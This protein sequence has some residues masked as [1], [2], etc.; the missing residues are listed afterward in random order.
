MRPLRLNAQVS[1]SKASRADALIQVP[2]ALLGKT[3]SQA[4]KTSR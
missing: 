1:A 3:E 4:L 2:V